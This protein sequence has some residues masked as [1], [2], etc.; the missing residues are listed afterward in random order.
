MLKAGYIKEAKLLSK[1]KVFEN[2][3][4]TTDI[5]ILNV[6]FSGDLDGGFGP[7]LAVFAGASKSFKTLLGLLCVRS[8]LRSDPEAIVLFYDSEFGATPD[9]FAGLNIDI[10]RVIH[11]PIKDIEELKFDIMPR[12]QEVGAKDKVMIFIDSVGNLASKKEVA[13]A[14]SKNEASDMTRAKQL[15]SVFRMVTPYL[16]MKK[17][18]CVAINHTYKTQEMYAKD[19]VS[20]GTGIYYSANTIFIITKAQVKDGTD[21]VGFTYTINIE[22]SRYIQ[23]K[24]K[25]PFTVTYKGGVSKYGSLF[26]LAMEAGYI[27]KTK[28]GWYN[29]VDPETGEVMNPA[30]REKEVIKNKDFFE[31]LLQTEGF[32]TYV[33]TRYKLASIGQVGD[34]EETE[35]EDSFD[36]EDEDM[37]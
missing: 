7:G 29:L 4:I 26:D 34:T 23:E 16:T 22:K 3:L 1:T 33:S 13:D 21:V 31:K 5:P 19:V 9:Y 18:P 28:V 10:D 30:L 35:A 6:A 25:L 8:F 15:K 24:A 36:P 27:S 37:E 20:G 2:E 32:K 12:L 11:I 17:I 14:L